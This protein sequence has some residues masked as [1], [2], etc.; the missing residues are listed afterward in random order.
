VTSRKAKRKGNKI[1]KQNNKGTK[2]RNA[3]PQD[4]SLPF[5]RGVSRVSSKYNLRKGL[6]GQKLPLFALK[7][8]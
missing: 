4:E 3:Q 2:G 6:L 8:K 1:Q 5:E 7:R